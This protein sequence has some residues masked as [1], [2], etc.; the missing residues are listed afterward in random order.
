MSR[1]NLIRYTYTVTWTKE[2]K[3]VFVSNK[4]LI[5]LRSGRKEQHLRL[6][7][8]LQIYKIPTTISPSWAFKSNGGNVTFTQTRNWNMRFSNTKSRGRLLV[9]QHLRRKEN[10]RGLQKL[11]ARD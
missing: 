4:T 5:S 8:A 2:L 9:Y 6:L 1:L 11:Q 10:G 7:R 3:Y